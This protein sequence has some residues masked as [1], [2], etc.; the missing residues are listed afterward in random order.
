MN[1]FQQLDYTLSI[2]LLYPLHFVLYDDQ[3]FASTLY[4]NSLLFSLNTSVL[5]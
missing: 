5:L 1:N 2:H 4:W 3:K